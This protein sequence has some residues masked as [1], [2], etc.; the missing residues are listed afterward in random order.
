MSFSLPSIVR[1]P[2]VSLLLLSGLFSARA[3][4]QAVN[5]P[6]V[7]LVQTSTRYAGTGSQ[8]FTGDF[9]AATSLALNQPSFIVVDSLGN[10]FVSD[11]QNNCVRRID[12]TG[13]MTTVAGLAVAGQGDTCNPS[14]NP[15]PASAQ[16]LLQPVGLAI[17]SGNNLYIA[18]SGHNCIRRLPAGSVG[19]SALTTVAGTCT[20]APATSPTPR[21]V[22][23]AFDRANNLYIAV[24]DTE[25]LPAVSTYQVLRH[26][27]A[28][29]AG[30]L[31]VVAG[32]PSAQVP[33]V[34]AGTAD[35]TVL[36]SPSGLTSDYAGR[37]YVADTGNNCVREIT[38]GPQTTIVGTCLNDP[39]S[40]GTSILHAPYGLAFTLTQAIYIT[41]SNPDNLVRYIPSTGALAVIAGL[42]NGTPGSYNSAQDGISALNVPLNKP[43][44]IVGDRNGNYYLADSLN[45]IVRQLSFNF[46]FPGSTPVGSFGAT[47][48][49]T[50]RINAP[51]NLSASTGPDYQ[52][53]SNSCLGTQTPATAGSPPNTCQIFVRFSPT[54][55][56][57]RYSPLRITDSISGT[58]VSQG[59]Q[60]TASGPLGVFVPGIVNTLVGN[61]ASPIA[62]NVD[63]AGNAYILERG[64]TPGS[65]DVRVVTPTGD[66]SR[67][68]IASGAGLITPT[69]IASDAAGD[70]FIADSA[71]GTITRFGTDGSVNP[72]YITG[73]IAPNALFADP[74][75]NLYIAQGGSAHNVVEYFASG[76]VRVI[77]GSGSV[78]AA[79]GIPST[80]AS[81]LSPSGVT[82]DLNGILYISDSG[83]HRVYAVDQTGLIHFAA[84][85]G[86]TSTTQL[87]VAIGTALQTPSSLATDAA[88]DLYIADTAA[89]RVYSVYASSASGTNI[90]SVIGTGTPGNSGDGGY[91]ILAQV[92][93]PLS[94]ATDSS[95]NVYIVDGGNNSVRRITY[96]NPTINFGKLLV[97][98]TSKTMLQYFANVGTDAL[99]L[100][101]AISTTDSRFAVD[102]NAT[103]CG[104]AILPGAVCYIGYNFTP[105]NTQSLTAFSILNSNSYNSPEPITLTGSGYTQIP[106]PITSSAETEVFGQPF[107]ET[108]AVNAGSGPAPTGNITYS[109]N[110]TTLCTVAITAP[111]TTCNAANS[112]LPVGTYTVTITYP[113]DNNYAPINS[114][115]T[116]TVTPAP[117]T[118]TGTSATRTYGQPNPTLSGTITGV[119]PGDT[120][121]TSFSTTATANSP[122]GSYAITPTFTA[123]GATNLSNYTITTVP[124]TLVITR[125]T[126]NVAVLNATRQY[127]QPNPPFTNTLTGAIAGDTFTFTYATP[128]T[129]ASPVGTY[130]VTLTVGGAAAANYN[131]TVTPGTLTVT[132]APLSVTVNNA[133][134]PYAAANPAFN[135]TITGAQNGDTF[136]ESFST[137]ATPASNVGTY[138]IN[139]A[140]SG[141]A[142]ANY[143]ITVTPGTLTITRAT[144]SVTITTGTYSRPYGSPNPTFT[145]TTTGAQNGDTFTVTY[146][147]SANAT[148][149]VGAYAIVPTVSGPAAAN[150]NF[151]LPNG[152]LNVTPAPLSVTALNASRTYGA[153]NPVFA[154]T[155]IG[156]VNGDV[157]T[158]NYTTPATVTSPV[159]TYAIV[160]SVSGPAASNYAVTPTNG[161][162]TV[163]TAPLN[164]ATANAT[165]AY[166]SP[167][168]TFTGN[169]T[170][171]LN[172]DTV[173]TTFTTAAT[174]SS[175]PGAYAI[176]PAISGP[177]AANYILTGTN[178][179][180]TVTKATL[181][182]TVT[183]N[184]VSRTYGAANP[185]FTSTVTGAVNGDTFTITYTTPATPASAVGTYAIIPTV[186]GPAA[187]NYNITP[188]NG[189][190]TINPAPLTVTANAAS[191]MYGAPNPVFTSTLTGVVNNDTLT[192]NYTTPAG[193]TSPVGTYAVTP[194]I[195]GPAASNYAVTA[196][197][198]VL[199]V[200]PAIASAT[201]TVNNATRV[202]GSPN[203]TFTGSVAGGLNGDLLG[204]AFTTAATSTSGVGTYPITAVLTGANAANYTA[205]VVPGTLT[206]TPAS[207]STAVTS[208][209]ST[210]VVG[211]NVTFTAT[212]TSPAGAPTGSVAFFDG[213]TQIGAATLGPNGTAAFSTTALA[214]GGRAITANY[215]GSTNFLGS[216]GA[217]NE[218]VTLA[219]GVFTL[220]ATPPS[221]FIRGAGSTAY[222]VTV[223]GV[224][225]FTGPVALTCSGLPADAT[226]VFDTPTV[227]VP[228]GGTVTTRM[229]VTTTVADASLVTPQQLRPQFDPSALGSITAAMVLPF[230]LGGFGILLA[231]IRRRRTV[232]PRRMRL[233]ALLVCSLGLFTLA[234]CGC[235]NTAFKTY[236]INVTGTSVN[237][238][239]PTQ[240]T[241]VVLSVGL[242][243]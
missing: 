87:G 46:I 160:P 103:T 5:T 242:P 24:S 98:Q 239:A 36:S 190:L 126:L 208:S 177:A 66:S 35:T 14:S 220:G 72:R 235:P 9:G 117:V 152:T 192:T 232:S 114:T 199:T 202:F 76:P 195:A 73:L 154:S 179:T 34:C 106:L 150:Y 8:G 174:A 110:G 97:G 12:V 40:N 142:A 74:F 91:S 138:P 122:A 240:T 44:G 57:L 205:T 193:A 137:P 176:N 156:T 38:G 241:S 144:A 185:A 7:S 231:G 18:D 115:T 112:T 27:Q 214:V 200:T 206:I 155:L 3:H 140:V 100:N 134:R 136:T 83:A 47:Q 129:P 118:I 52:I 197:N 166:G 70:W 143:T 67:L 139:D 123:V 93:G 133:T 189:T 153:A 151:N 215:L 25:A 163:T 111:T 62:V 82:L 121:L 175:A 89:N 22:G 108:I 105:T 64:N 65:A 135:S 211:G 146:T 141:P 149:P 201:I 1:F 53:T 182:L 60:G 41:E 227:N 210:V 148:S 236:T 228:T 32:T 221:Q 213:A 167:N 158:V 6:Q 4:A 109:V 184:N 49:L 37:I 218:V 169:T 101:S 96:P 196:N 78:S 237:G 63:S 223:G 107:P 230:E 102:S 128:A 51:V 50:F 233:L 116:L 171:L 59:L 29:P 187:A 33:N 45:N 68:A 86:T 222:T 99:N 125:A 11:T 198:G 58:T 104:T 127:G 234:G 216:T 71:Q 20:A 90:A 145:S 157:L 194:S 165:R 224:G 203:P 39:A 85:N 77:A 229:V 79:D 238:N 54:R 31:C 92:N 225:S 28:D 16:G 61:L 120:I 42:P 119:V 207:T 188:V 23:L 113:G 159:G 131:I 178:G 164:V 180:L 95:A 55:P 219:P 161:T 226:C 13:N 80:Q 147:T 183:A 170:G 132:P 181:P 162:L 172:G 69:A 217:V 30:T 168:P 186:S 173:V 243:N 204:A 56:G 124:G 15:T 130:P 88:G 10:Q 81:F 75:G 2:L 17:D 191:R 94:V 19:A 21:P 212:V 209:P 26:T 48:P 84:G 43:R